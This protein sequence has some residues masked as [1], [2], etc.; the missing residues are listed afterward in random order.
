MQRLWLSTILTLFACLA[1]AQSSFQKA[2]NVLAGEQPVKVLDSISKEQA[3]KEFT[4]LLKESQD[5]ASFVIAAF[6]LAMK[7]VDVDKNLARLVAPIKDSH[8]GKIDELTATHGLAENQV[9]L[10]DIPN[11]IYLIYRTRHYTPALKTLLT[12]PVDWPAAEYRDDCIMTQL[13]TDAKP[14]LEMAQDV[15]IYATVWDIV[16]WNVGSMNDRMKF[17]ARLK[18]TRWPNASTKKTALRLAHD[19]AT[20][21][22]RSAK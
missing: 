1:A 22:N 17:V 20:P 12:M 2:A 5:S 19:V 21:K 8:D 18:T 6:V 7:G 11:A 3:I 10:E 14:V 4:P 9:L 16:D 15:K 13:R